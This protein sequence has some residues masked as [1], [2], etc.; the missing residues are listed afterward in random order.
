MSYDFMFGSGQ[1]QELPRFEHDMPKPGTSGYRHDVPMACHECGMTSGTFCP[2]PAIRGV[3]REI[4]A[5][6]RRVEAL[7]ETVARA[8]RN[9][10]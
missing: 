7:E 5:L 4:Q 2:A 10:R 6:S 1:S 8:S 3:L 9:T